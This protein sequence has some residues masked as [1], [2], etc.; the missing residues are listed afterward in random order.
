MSV[1]LHRKNSLT[2]SL[3]YKFIT[4]LLTSVSIGQITLSTALL[5]NHSLFELF[6][7]VSMQFVTEVFNRPPLNFQYNW[8]I[9]IRQL[10]FRL[11]VSAHH[12]KVSFA[13]HFMA[14]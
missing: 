10:T 3:T 4:E 2:H 14:V 13:P 8:C 1:Y 12:A 9:V 11:R 5:T 6:N 7:D